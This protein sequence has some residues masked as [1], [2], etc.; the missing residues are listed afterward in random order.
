MAVLDDRKL[1]SVSKRLMGVALLFAVRPDAVLVPLMAEHSDSVTDF[2]P[3]AAYVQRGEVDRGHS[4]LPQ[5]RFLGRYPESEDLRYQDRGEYAMAVPL[6][7][8][9]LTYG[10]SSLH[11]E[12]YLYQ[13]ISEDLYRELQRPKDAI[14]WARGAVVRFPNDERSVAWLG[15]LYL[16]TNQPE[17]VEPLW[18][19]LGQ[20]QRVRS[21]AHFYQMGQVDTSR[22]AI[23]RAV[24]ALIQARECRPGDMDIA[25]DLAR[26]YH[27]L[28][29]GQV[30]WLLFELVA[31]TA[32][33]PSLRTAAATALASGTK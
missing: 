24:D 28:G 23:Q 20:D 12:R 17:Q 31:S 26:V 18:K 22:G 14:R 3:A 2:M 16:W 15:T 13:T 19:T 1:T 4:L 9:A 25:Y 5:I 33:R 32:T 6:I 11:D 10:Q 30:A 21:C 7:E 27:R 8:L 29:N